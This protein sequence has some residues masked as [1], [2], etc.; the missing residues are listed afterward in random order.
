[1]AHPK[2]TESINKMKSQGIRITPQRLAVLEYLIDSEA[3]PTADDIYRALFDR[4]P[5]MSPATVY[6][7]LHL[8]IRLG[9]VK[10][11]TYGDGSSRFDFTSTEHYHAICEVCGDVSDLYYPVLDDVADIADSLIGFKVSKHRMEV[12]GICLNCQA[13]MSSN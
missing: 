11:L 12:Y 1:M 4:F 9:F 13:E 2:L 5:N 6:N 8:F 3:H 10:E 7:N